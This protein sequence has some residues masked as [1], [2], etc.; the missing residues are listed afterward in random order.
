MVKVSIVI[1]LYRITPFIS[2]CLANLNAHT[3][4]EETEIIIVRSS[5]SFSENCNR[6]ISL[7][8]GEY[9]CL[10]N[11][12]ICVIEN[13][14]APLIDVLDTRP[15]AG[16]VSPM[17]LFPFGQVQFGGMVFH[18][19]YCG[20]HLGW[21][22]QKEDPRLLK[23][24]TEFQATTFGCVL[25]RRSALEE[26][27][28]PTIVPDVYL[29]NN[30][31]VL[32]ED[33]KVGGYEDVDLCLRM[34]LVGWKIFYQ[35]DSKVIHWEST[36]FKNMNQKTRLE[37]SKSNRELYLNRWT[38]YFKDGAFKVDDNDYEGGLDNYA[39]RQ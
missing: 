21:G 12:D 32:D 2:Q 11:D 39:R 18:D 27:G 24:V 7:A 33:F 35:P 19:D 38:Q 4:S 20:G 26:C 3:N 16:A 6:G 29:R 36:T 25:L 31:K 37:A 34:K 9:I 22:W 30:G 1:P 23:E 5:G 13:W 28:Y 10:L 8:K 14:L 17:M 15:D